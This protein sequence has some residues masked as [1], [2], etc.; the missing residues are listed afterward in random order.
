MTIRT[1]MRNA[2]TV[3][4]LGLGAAACGVAPQPL[5]VGAEECAHCRMV[6]A[7]PQFAAQALNAK[8]KAFSFDAVECLAAWVN[9]GE[10]PMD[11]LHSAWVADHAAPHDW[12]RVEEATFLRTPAVHTPMGMGMV[13]HR[14]ASQALR[15]QAQRGGEI[16]RWDEVLRVVE[17]EGG[18]GAHGA[19]DHA[20]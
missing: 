17:R 16:L 18:H 1:T 14:D 12:V 5:Q 4:L 11:D 10:L 15:M 8:G 3:L 2:L 20:H 7:E 6:V 9:S 13:A 19:G